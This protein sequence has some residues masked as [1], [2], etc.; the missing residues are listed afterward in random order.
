MSGFRP[1][2]ARAQGIDNETI[3][4]GKDVIK[5]LGRMFYIVDPAETTFKDLASLPKDGYISTGNALLFWYDYARM[6]GSP[7]KGKDTKNK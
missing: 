3:I 7:F 5:N 4:T 2:E 6:V 1:L